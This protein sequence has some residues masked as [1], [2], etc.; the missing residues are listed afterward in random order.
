MNSR[1]WAYLRQWWTRRRAVAVMI[2]AAPAWLV[3]LMLHIVLLIVISLTT[4]ALPI[5]FQL[6]L[7]VPEEKLLEQPQEFHFQEDPSDAIG[8][9]SDDGLAIAMAAAPEVTDLAEV[10]EQPEMETADYGNIE[11][12]ETTEFVSAALDT[13]KKVVRGVAGVS[14][15]GAG[16]AIDRITHEIRLSLEDKDTL[17]VWLFDE[18]GSLDRQRRQ[19]NARLA[20]IYEELGLI[21]D[22]I[23]NPTSNR[24]PLLT[25]IMS[26]GRRP[27]W[28]IR[29]PTAD[30]ASMQ[31][32]VSSIK[33]DDSGIENVFQA[34][35]T[36]ADEVKKWRSR[37]NIMLIAVTDEVGDDQRSMSEK[38]VDF[39][40][41]KVMP[42]YVLGV[43]A[44]FGEAE[45]ELKWVD[46]DPK[47]DQTPKWGRVNQGPES[48]RTE[49]LQLPFTNGAS[50]TYDSGFGPFALTRL[51]YQTGGIYFAIHPNRRTDGRVRRREIDAFTSHF[52]YF[53]DPQTMRHYRPDYVSIS[54][55]DRRAKASMARS[56][57]V[58][59]AQV[60]T[61]RLENPRL[62]FVKRDDAQF[63][64]ALTDGQKSAAKLQ[65]KINALY[66]VLR[67][68]E[69]DRQREQSL[70]WRA[71]YDLALGQTIAVRVRTQAYNEMLA[72]AKRGLKPKQERN[73]T[74]QLV[75]DDELSTSSRLEKD[76][77]KAKELLQ[78]VVDEHNG[79]PWALLAQKELAVPLGWRWRESF[80][81]MPGNNRMA[82]ANNNNNPVIPR[83]DVKRMLPKR[84]QSRKVPKL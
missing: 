20:R 77:A 1:P 36:A 12:M 41:K 56:A 83:D 64:N 62:R 60:T 39:C 66:E 46:P 24:Q 28:R 50:E 52:S 5:P 61:A 84:P 74:W 72:K 17:V 22:D 75:P 57:V 79:T 3:S 71:A 31:A 34:I 6:T 40:R 14:V 67:Q 54:E 49:R 43:P 11:L 7:S 16:G 26:F 8:A 48:L 58:R 65:P 35:Y 73:N 25:A 78:Q 19:I 23:L 76:A 18:S 2:N 63:A 68:G 51:C 81:P 53:F 15:T 42:V 21:R 70:R 32:A 59:A 47:Y 37:R 27:N 55:Y 33:L 4:Y 44:A 29:K 82:A 30:V 10:F 9:L 13:N 80:T 69:E 38:C 45:T